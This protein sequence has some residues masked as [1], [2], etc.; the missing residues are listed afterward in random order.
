MRK[1]LLLGIAAVLS[2]AAKA[3]TSCNAGFTWT[4][5]ANTYS[6]TFTKAGTVSPAMPP[7]NQSWTSQYIMNVTTMPTTYINYTGNTATYNFGAPGTYNLVA[8]LGYNDSTNNIQ[9]F[10]TTQYSITLTAQ[11]CAVA[12]TSVTGSGVSRTFTANG[13]TAT[14][15]TTYSWAWGDGTPNGSGVS[16][17]HTYAAAGTYTVT[18]TATGNGCTN[19]ANTVVTIGAPLN[20]A[21]VSN[22]FTT[23]GTGA[24][25][26]F[27]PVTTPTNFSRTNFWNFGNGN[28]AVTYNSNG[29]SNTFATAGT[30]TV[31]LYTTWYDSANNITCYDTVCQNVTTTTNGAFNCANASNAVTATVNGSTVTLTPTVTPLNTTGITV[32]NYWQFG[33]GWGAS[34]AYTSPQSLYFT[35]GGTYT[36]RWIT[37]WIQNSNQTVLCR[38]TAYATYTVAAP[39]LINGFVQSDSSNVADTF[40]VYLITYNAQTNMLQAVDSTVV[41]GYGYAS[42]QF[43]NKPAGVYRTK[44]LKLNQTVGAAGYVPTYRD[45][46][47]TWSAAQTFA[48][49]NGYTWSGGVYLKQGTVTSGPGFVGGNVT[50]GANKGA[51]DGDPVEG[52]LVF[53]M[54]VAG[55]RMIASAYTN[56]QGQYSFSNIPVGTYTVYPEEMNYATT[57]SAMAT[58]TAASTSVTGIGFRKDE[59]NYTLKPASA[60]GVRN[61]ASTGFVMMPNPAANTLTIR[62]GQTSGEAQVR[63]LNVA[64][65]IVH[66]AQYSAAKSATLDVSLLPTGMYT[67]QVA[68]ADGMATEKLMIAR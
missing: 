7:S 53:L 11:P 26:Y 8:Y 38:D 52:Q 22:N 24:T 3:Q 57:P 62:F 33:N 50:Q 30:Y 1:I 64:G 37:N 63:V 18:V 68:T 45:S 56:A 16:A 47:L 20:C 36:A 40:Q 65:Q 51:A 43:A 66:N 46:S 42:F 35:T 9:C 27:T 55:N 17:S 59:M 54:D 5:N 58:I 21:N 4:Q 41:A 31:C 10:D 15:G 49:N 61:V 29:V 14:A 2:V 32:Q 67:V 6:V 25:R 28:T 13:G 60:A 12:V 34:G 48:H 44:A 23:T 39:N 19:T